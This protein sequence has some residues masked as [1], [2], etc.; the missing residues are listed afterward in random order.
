MADF[1]QIQKQVG[2]PSG[3]IR[4]TFYEIEGEPWLDIVSATEYNKGYF[5]GLLKRQRR[6]RRSIRTGNVSVNTIQNNRK[7]DLGLYAEH[8]VKG[9]GNVMDS[10][11]KKVSFSKAVCADFSQRSSKLDLRRSQEFRGRPAVL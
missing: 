10:K 9:W 1:S 2:E 6:N 5:N 3:T 7:E 4:Y 11:G 8:I